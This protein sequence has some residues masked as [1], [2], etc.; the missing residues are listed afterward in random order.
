MP[1]G[2]NG[3]NQFSKSANLQNNN[4][5]QTQAAEMLNVSPRNVASVAAK[6]ANLPNGVRADRSS[7]N[8]QSLSPVT[9]AQAAEML[10]VSPRNVRVWRLSWLIC[11]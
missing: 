7:A 6:L 11:Q 4:V 5:T 2:G 9:Q 3:N 8:L 10:N 1:R